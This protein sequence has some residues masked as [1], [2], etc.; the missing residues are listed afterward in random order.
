MG[1][2][3]GGVACARRGWWV[4]AGALV[5]LAVTSQQFAL[6]VLA[7]LLVVAPSSHRV[8][9]AAAASGAAALIV[10]PMIA[11]T[12]GRAFNAVA[13]GSGNTP[14]GGGTVLWELHLHGALLVAVSRVLPIAL[15]MVLA[16]WAKRHLGPA[17]L[18]PVPLMSLVATSL[19]FR[20]VFE[21]NL[22][23]YYFMALAVSLILL[24]VVQGRIRG[25][26]VAWLALVMLAFDSA[27]WG[28]D[29]LAH[30]LP[31]WFWQVSLV[32]V[33]I[34]LASGPLAGLRKDRPGRD[35]RG[36]TCGTLGEQPGPL[37]PG[38]SATAASGSSTLKLKL[39]S[40]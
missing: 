25:Q 16:W 10:V 5:G 8:R 35:L 31:I 24:D 36:P 22:F 2:A 34:A 9:F 11:L 23:G 21:Q 33:G 40:I 30:G 37:Q 18:E 7:P 17:V 27:P 6:L 39:S 28:S 32:S 3:L 20:L 1:L 14:S 38:I 29:P 4:W 12:S 19:C 15:A 13:I 26:L